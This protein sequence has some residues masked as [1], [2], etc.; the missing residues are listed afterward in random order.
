MTRDTKYA[1]DLASC[2]VGTISLGLGAA[3]P[4]TAD[5][6]FTLSDDFETDAATV[7]AW[8]HSPFVEELPQF[9]LTGLLHYEPGATGRGLGF[10]HGS[11]LWAEG[12]TPW[13]IRLSR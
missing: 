12:G 6:V 3:V 1:H 9:N 13:I 4:T 7:D 11:L 10:R 5:E 2:V 8:Y